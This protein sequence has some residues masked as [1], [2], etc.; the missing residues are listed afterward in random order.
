MRK[1]INKLRSLPRST[2][3]LVGAVIAAIAA[4][5]LLLAWGPSDR[6]TYTM[7]N[8]ADHV[9]FNS[10]TDNPKHGDERNFVQI[11]NF[12]DNGKFGEEVNLIPGKEYEVYVYYHND[13]AENLNSAEHNYKGIA[14]GAFMRVEMP[15]V[16]PAGNSG[17]ING[18]V[19]ATNATPQ[20][21]WDEAYAKNTSAS[22]IVLRYVQNSAII[23]SNGA[24][25]GQQVDLTKLAGTNG[26]PLGYDKLDGKLPG[27]GEYAG[28]VTYRFKAVQPNFEITKEVSIAGKNDFKENVDVKPGDE[29]QYRIQYKNTG[30]VQ[31]DNVVIRDELPKGVTYVAGSTNIF[32]SRTNGQWSNV[33]EDTITKQGI[34]IGSYAP[35]GNAYIVFKAKVASKDQLEK[36]GVN[37]LVNVAHAETE[38]GGK[39]D[40]AT[41]TVTKDCPKPEPKKEIVC[42]LKTKKYPVTINEGEF[43]SSKYSRNPDDC[44]EQP[45]PEYMEVCVIEE[46]AI[47]PIEKKDFDSTKHTTDLSKCEDQPK[48]PVTPTELPRTGA[49][50]DVLN[51]LGLGA[52][53]TASLAYVA[54]RKN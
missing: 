22:S 17:R 16:V 24:V 44:K 39:S 37:K 53:V 23:H 12:T 40:S 49:G 28:Y 30:T 27:C 15:D 47:K 8:P 4:P 6:P 7:Q 54:S 32:N 52:L 35:N 43:D 41:V 11:R 31:Q 9:T 26:A 14:Q 2:N 42:E 29:V 34:N 13:A 18:F 36:C 45:K 48:T 20:Q 38:N 25:N 33:K 10:I 1:F 5:A 3:V 46:K 21:V 51:A 19:G 50:M